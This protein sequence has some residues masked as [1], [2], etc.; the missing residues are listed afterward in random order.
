MKKAPSNRGSVHIKEICFHLKSNGR[1]RQTKVR[2]YICLASRPREDFSF[3]GPR[4][5]SKS[6][7]LRFAAKRIMVSG[8]CR[9]A[10]SSFWRKRLWISLTLLSKCFR[11]SLSLWV[12][13]S[14]F[15]VSSTCWKDMV[16][17]TPVPML[18]C[19]K[20]THKRLIDS[21]LLFRKFC[22]RTFFF[23]ADML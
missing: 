23:N 4:Y 13:V 1:S 17:T 8:V 21:S 14:V 12:P 22:F 10:A 5:T 2:Q 11:P 3:P 16:M 7:L 18:M 6:T 9:P 20:E 19:H 15:G